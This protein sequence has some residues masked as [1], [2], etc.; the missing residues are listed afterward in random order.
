[1]NKK[2]FTIIVHQY[3]KEGVAEAEIKEA[4]EYIL[5]IVIKE[6]T[7]KL[8]NLQQSQ[9]DPR[10][11]ILYEE[12]EDYDDFINVQVKRPYRKKFAEMQE[13]LGTE[14]PAVEAGV[15]MNFYTS[16]IKREK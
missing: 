8:L 11:Y 1:M 4:F 15:W 10:Q 3:A 5:D 12:W 16:I 13:Q 9:S 14:I 7:C 2:S 6:P